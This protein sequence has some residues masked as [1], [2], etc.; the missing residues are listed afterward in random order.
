MGKKQ[1]ARKAQA[2]PELASPGADGAPLGTPTPLEAPDKKYKGLQDIEEECLRAQYGDDFKI[3]EEQR[4]AWSVS[5][6]LGSTFLDEATNH[7]TE[8]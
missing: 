6:H 1:R 5:A 7:S 2:F 3:E 4:T 8:D